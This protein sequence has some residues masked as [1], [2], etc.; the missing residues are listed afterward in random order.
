MFRSN[1]SKILKIVVFFSTMEKKLTI[2]N[3]RV[4]DI[5]L[6]LAQMER[7]GIQPMLD[8]C[9]P[10]HGNWHG[11][12][13]G[14]TSVI[15]LSHIL[16][17]GD[18]RLNHVQDWAVKHL[19]TLRGC[20]GQEVRDLDFSDDR[21]EEILDALS[22]DQRWLGFEAVLNQHVIRV[23]DLDHTWCAWTVPPLAATGR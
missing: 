17:L 10:T 7:M 15:W 12:S 20:T 11:I 6:L 1:Y 4:D 13:L 19:E 8:E 2:T 3:E 22:D 23:Y 18:H 14:W 5:P 21:L 9:F 16:S